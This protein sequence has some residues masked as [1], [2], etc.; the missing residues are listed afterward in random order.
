MDKFTDSVETD[1][2]DDL[3]DFPQ[4]RGARIKRPVDHK[5]LTLDVTNIHGTP[6]AA[7]ATLIPV[8]THCK[9]G[10]FGNHEGFTLREFMFELIQR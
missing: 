2:P 6:R 7:I 8:I 3:P 9:Y 5:R 4:L 1:V 10:A